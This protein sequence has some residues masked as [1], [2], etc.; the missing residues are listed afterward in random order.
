[1]LTS[2]SDRCGEEEQNHL[3][4]A[5]RRHHFPQVAA[6]G[7]NDNDKHHFITSLKLLCKQLRFGKQRKLLCISFAGYLQPTFQIVLNELN[8][9]YHVKL[10]YHMIWSQDQLKCRLQVVLTCPSSIVTPHLLFQGPPVAWG[11]NCG[12][13]LV[14]IVKYSI[15]RPGNLM[16]KVE[17]LRPLF[18]GSS[19][20]ER[21][22]ARSK[23]GASATTYVARQP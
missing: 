8:I 9:I 13:V 20:R 16:L 11:L 14:L 23:P 1:M 4:L 6:H 2:V 19:A 7:D 21:R 3:W 18:L 15:Q 10:I 17:N 5:Q 12:F 22:R